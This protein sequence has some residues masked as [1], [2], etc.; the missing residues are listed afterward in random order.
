MES[1][2]AGL[3]AIWTAVSSATQPVWSSMSP[4]WGVLARVPWL[5]LCDILIMT[6]LVYSGIFRLFL[7]NAENP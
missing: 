2:L 3:Q 1:V 4:V 6:C 5:A 7:N